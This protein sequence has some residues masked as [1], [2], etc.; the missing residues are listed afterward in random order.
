MTR[1]TGVPVSRRVAVLAV[2][3][4]S[5]LAG[6]GDDDA[7]GDEVGAATAPAPQVAVRDAWARATVPAAPTGAVFVELEATTDDA[8]VGV[9][10]EA[11]VAA[12]ATVHETVV[13]PVAD[14]HGAADQEMT[15]MRPLDRLAL[16]AGEVVTLESGGVH[17]MLTGLAAPLAAGTT[18]EVTLVFERAGPQPVTVEVREDQS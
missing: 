8:L 18:I 2:T 9:E 5:V 16:P 13:E 11:D 14:Q 17:V 12:G 7:S 1:P 10:V 6:C 15:S 3:A 4:A